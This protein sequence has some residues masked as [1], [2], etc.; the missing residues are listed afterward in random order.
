MSANGLYPV[1]GPVKSNTSRK[2]SST[3]GAT[4][5]SMTENDDVESTSDVTH[6]DSVGGGGEQSQQDDA[7]TKTGNRSGGSEYTGGT[8]QLGPDCPPVSP[9]TARRLANNGSTQ[10]ADSDLD[11]GELSCK[12]SSTAAKKEKK[13]TKTGKTKSVL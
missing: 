12:M 8:N 5:D 4:T 7:T 9:T 11:D 10:S 1:T 2:T 6:D 13:L 3:A